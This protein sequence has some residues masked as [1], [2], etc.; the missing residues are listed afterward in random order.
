M[1][2]LILILVVCILLVG[3]SQGGSAVATI[4]TEERAALT[5]TPSAETVREEIVFELTLTPQAPTPTIEIT[6]EPT[7]TP[8]PF[9][10]LNVSFYGADS[11]FYHIDLDQ[12]T[13]QRI[14]GMSYPAEGA[15]ITYDDLRYVHILYVDFEGQTHE[16]E[17]IVNEQV[18]NEVMDIFYQLYLAEYPLSS[19][20]LVDDYGE[21]FEDNLS[22]AANNTSAFNYRYSSANKLSRHAYGAAIDINPMMNPYIH[23]DGRVSPSNAADWVDRSDVRVGMIDKNDLCYQLFTSYGWE[24]GGNFRSE[25]DYQHFSKDLGY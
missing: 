11:N 3:C 7:A 16:G 6:P 2:R 18:A 1:K 22:M 13:R 12:M 25:K 4:P 17:L 21:P 14:T 24:W 5:P 10:G 23:S 20:K 19:V 9:F 15:I 8:D